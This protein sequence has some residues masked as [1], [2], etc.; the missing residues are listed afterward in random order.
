MRSTVAS[1]AI[2]PKLEFVDAAQAA[3]FRRAALQPKRSLRTTLRRREDFPN[4]HS[5]STT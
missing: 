2:L 3:V 5:T 1:L 4:L